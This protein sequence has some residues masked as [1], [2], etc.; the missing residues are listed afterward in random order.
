MP[1]VRRRGAPGE[2]AA[3]VAR[4]ML[5]VAVGAK[6]GVLPCRPLFVVQSISGITPVTE[7]AGDE[8]TVNAGST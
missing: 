7:A 4:V 8:P 5:V 1:S 2:P 6:W 3:V